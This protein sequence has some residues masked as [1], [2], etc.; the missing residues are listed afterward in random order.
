MISCTPGAGVSML[1]ES[2][3]PPSARIED[4]VLDHELVAGRSDPPSPCALR[5]ARFTSGLVARA[6]PAVLKRLCC[7]CAGVN[8]E[9]AGPDEA[10]SDATRCPL[11]PPWRTGDPIAVERVTA[12]PPPPRP[13]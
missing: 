7:I 11:M 8:A 9:M 4:V 12:W 3:A 13:Q 10:R 2:G 5:R 6:T 1:F